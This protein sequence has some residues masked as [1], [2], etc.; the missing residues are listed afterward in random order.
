M[1]HS[2][3]VWM[4][5]EMTG[6]D[7]D[8]E[9]IIEVAVLVT[10]SELN[11]I[12]EGP[13]LVIHQP[14]A[15]LEGMDAWNKE[16]HGRSGLIDRVKASTLSEAEAEEQ[17]LAFIKK[18][19]EEKASPLAGNSIHHDR[20]FLRR[21]MPRIHNYLHYRIIDVSS[22]KELVKRW[23]PLTHRTQPPKKEDHRAMDDIRESLRELQ[24]YRDHAFK[25]RA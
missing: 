6:L 24:Y 13:S 9:R 23:Y 5:L 4:D 12:E 14:D 15:L 10:D 16:H 18:H 19:T 17:V 3:I 2:N 22:V 25:P 11:V 20:L 1:G 7:P 21:Y 8:R